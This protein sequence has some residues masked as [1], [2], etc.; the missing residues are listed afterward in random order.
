MGTLLA[1]LAAGGPAHAEP[2][3]PPAQPAAPAAADDLTAEQAASAEAQRTGAPVEVLALRTEDEIVVA[4]PDGSF[5]SEATAGPQRAQL[6]D[7]SWQAVDPRLEPRGGFIVPRVGAADLKLSDGGDTTLIRLADGDRAMVLDWPRPLPAPRVDGTVATY[8]EVLSG[9]DLRVQAASA[10]FSYVL[11]VKSAQAA[12]NAHLADITLNVRGEGLTV[13]EA[14][15]G[16]LE[17]V[18]GAGEPVFSGAAPAMWDSSGE[19]K[20]PKTPDVPNGLPDDH[21]TAPVVVNDGAGP[22]DQAAAPT[23]GDR[24]AD[25]PMTVTDGQVAVVPDPALLRGTDTTYPVYIDPAASI[26]KS[27]WNYVSEDRPG[28]KYHKFDDDEGV[29]FCYRQGSAVCSTSGYVNRMYFKFTPTK[30]HWTER[31][32]DKVVFRAYETFSF[33]CSPSWIDLHL[34]DETKVNANLTWNNKPSDGDLMV[35]RK[36]AYGRGSSCDPDSDPS[37]V[38][39]AD[40]ADE[41]DENLTKTVRPRL[42]AG[43]AVAFS[44]A[45]KDEKDPNSWKRF[46]G[47]NATLSVTYRSRPSKPFG[48]RM[49]A[50][51]KPC[52]T[53]AGRPF[54]PNDKPVLVAQATDPDS[55]NISVRFVLTDVTTGK[56]V[57]TT[58]DGPK[59]FKAS[60]KNVDYKAQVSPDL[61]HGHTYRWRA[62]AKDD[63]LESLSWSDFCE[64]SVDREKPNAVPA[65]TSTDFPTDAANKKPG[66]P[67]K[68]VFAANGV[69]DSAYGNDVAY[70]EWAIGDDNPQ[71]KAVPAATG[72][73]AEATVTASTFGPNVLYVRSVDRAGNRGDVARYVFRAVRPCDDPAAVACSA[74]D[75]LFDETTGTTAADTSGKNRPLTLAGVDRVDGQQATATDRTDRAVRFDGVADSA[76]GASVVDTRQGFTVAAWVRPTA[77]GR[78]MTV[79]SQAGAHNSGFTLGYAADRQRWVFG[80]YRHDAVNPAATDLVEVAANTMEPPAVNQWTYLVGYFDPGKNLLT[81]YVDGQEAG[82][83]TYTGTVWNAGGGLQLGRAKANDKWVEP[84]A[85]DVD[86][87]RVYPGGLD[88]VDIDQLWRSSRPVA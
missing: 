10:G 79:V 1:G 31:V 59:A 61:V 64:Y 81:L 27:D 14:A 5:T 12:K 2:P 77:L 88:A 78:D 21:G 73:T 60:G 8:P 69:K 51:D 19:R 55:Q 24:T 17:A 18:D 30:S 70:Y 53:G 34:V 62:I 85:G 28:T 23:P 46:E 84:F 7:G 75:Y 11:V 3:Q 80:R 32:V 82:V 52:V 39:F 42:A 41:T 35:D 58:T 15:G 50:P 45:A 86:D 71:N 76:S 47:D 29:G 65:V 36:V 9:V 63:K 72:G 4:N 40:N 33:T 68:V 44:L 66:E 6:A 48:E 54:L 25:L 56:D 43:R 37:W 49:T 57:Q 38:E 74:A 13:R 83:A 16:G 87:L 22:I 26:T 20:P 67:G